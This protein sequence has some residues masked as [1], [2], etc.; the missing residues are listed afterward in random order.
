MK[1]ILLLPIHMGLTKNVLLDLASIFWSWEG[2]VCWQTETKSVEIFE[3][4]DKQKNKT[5][6]ERKF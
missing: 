3:K 6:Q 4:T 5:K 2:S 1:T